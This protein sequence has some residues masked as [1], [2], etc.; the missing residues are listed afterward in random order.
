M[1]H[2]V[3]SCHTF[4]HAYFSFC[5]RK[6]PVQTVCIMSKC[7]ILR[8]DSIMGGYWIGPFQ[9]L[10]CDML[11]LV[12]QVSTWMS[13]ACHK[14]WL[15]VAFLL[16]GD[17]LALSGW[18]YIVCTMTGSCWHA[19]PTKS[20]LPG[21]FIPVYDAGLFPAKW[22]HCCCYL[23]HGKNG[24]FVSI[25]MWIECARYPNHVHLGFPD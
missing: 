7:A 19:V 8:E 12:C 20:E 14:S 22:N 2:G 10:N 6:W 24:W 25:T 3:T 11:M 21:Y 15:T 16:L 4:G 17:R 1:S 18:P 23:C 9:T 5:I 13:L